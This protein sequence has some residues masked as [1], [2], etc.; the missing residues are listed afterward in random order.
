[1]L[2]Q[3]SVRQ[4]LIGIIAFFCILQVIT[5]VVILSQL[6]AAEAAI[7]QS[8]SE[9][10]NAETTMASI[11]EQ[12]GNVKSTLLLLL[13]LA[14]GMAIGIGGLIVNSVKTSL[15]RARKQ[16]MAMAAGDLATPI[17]ATGKDEIN[18]LLTHLEQ[19]RQQVA[20]M[21]KII[22][23][24]AQEVTG[25]LQNQSQSSG[26]IRANVDVQTSEIQHVTTAVHQMAIAVEEVAENSS[27]AHQATEEVVKLA[28][29][30]Q[31]ANDKST[32]MSS[33]LVTSLDSSADALGELER[34][35]QN[36]S[37]V[38]DVIKGIA[39]QTNLLALNA[40][41]EAARAGEQGRGFAVVADEVRTLAQRTQE[42]TVEIEGMVSQFLSG[43]QAAATSMSK[44]SGLGHETIRFARVAGEQMVKISEA[45][46]G[47]NDLNMQVASAVE[48]QTSVAGE[49][50][51]NVTRVNGAA[52][53]ILNEISSASQRADGILTTISDM[54][55]ALVCFRLPD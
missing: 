15:D 38:L 23:M 48:E 21:M 41:I 3:L 25:G 44:S 22:Q 2:S 11:S 20:G 8:L 36:I 50:S 6:S 39:E 33:E 7:T 13:V 18:E 10:G 55:Q 28:R 9:G 27:K 31:E 19:M 4:R 24:T 29:T 35:S 1:M 42:S 30:G 14:V 43:A 40:A 5:D 16:I 37:K 45:I 46:A 54:N 53:E 52:A 12:V 51:Q 26:S 32:D 49:V 17:R 47:I 34:N